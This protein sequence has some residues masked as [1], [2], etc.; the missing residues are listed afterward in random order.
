MAP[1]GNFRQGSYVLIYPGRNGPIASARLEMLREGIEDWEVMN[2]VRKKHGDASVR[3]LLAG[4][5]STTSA[6]AKLGCTI[7]CPIKT[8]TPYSWPTYSHNAGTSRTLA[9]MRAAALQAAS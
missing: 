8:S 4:L 7:G 6:G 1:E 2:V 3:R 9:S 5:F